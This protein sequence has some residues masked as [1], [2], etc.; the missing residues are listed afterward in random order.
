MSLRVEVLFT[1]DLVGRIVALREPGGKPAP[2]FYLGR[3]AHGNLWRFRDDLRSDQLRSLARLASREPPLAEDA[4]PPERIQAFREV[5]LRAG[6]I[7]NEYCG[8][9]F[10]FPAGLLSADSEAP[11]GSG[12]RVIELGAGSGELLRE[13]FGSMASEIGDLLP[14]FGLELAGRVVCVCHSARRFVGRAAEAGVETLPDQRGKSFAPRVVAAWAREVARQGEL[15]LYSTS[16]DNSASRSV[17]H[18]LG[19][20]WLGEDLHFS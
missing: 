10:G 6:E 20:V 7:R 19:L 2:S 15:P 17:A 13:D 1:H 8:P 3:S 12:G 9:A 16:W 18:R 11:G 4:S 5:L 14:C